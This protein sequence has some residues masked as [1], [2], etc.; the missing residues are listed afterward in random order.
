M[1]NRLIETIKR[2]LPEVQEQS[3]ALREILLSNLVMISE[4]PSPTFNEADRVHFLQ[5]RFSE[6]GL[7]NCSTD[8]VGNALGVLPGRDE[9][10]NI[11]VV[12]HADTVFPESVDHTVSVHEQFVTGAG[13][14]DDGLGL[15][16][17]CTLPTLLER[18]D[19]QLESSLV[20]MGASRSL[21]RGNLEGLRFFLDNNRLPIQAGVCVEGVQL[22]RLSLASIGML[23]G[24]IVCRV[25]DEYDWTR[26]GMTSAIT[27]LNEIITRIMELP[28]PTR[29]RTSIVLGSIRGGTSHGTIARK[30][31]LGF[32]I[33]SE[34]GEVTRQIA[35]D[36]EDRAAEVASQSGSEVTFDIFASRKPGGV[37]F[38]HP[39][40]R[41]TREI[42]KELSI[43]SR[44]APSTSELSAFID[45]GI[46]AITIGMTTCE[47]LNDLD[48]ELHIAPIS[49]GLAQLL[50]IILAIDGG[51]CD[52]N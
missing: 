49:T 20:L 17:L 24:E 12:A 11:L 50:G 33:R 48:E 8:E 5:Q 35:Q 7:Q 46:P 34:S 44:V 10:R 45:S 25:S 37:S 42:M 16:V 39:L 47:K 9:N 38:S 22:G 21:G 18:L 19:I 30:A 28:I 14:A 13:V 52:D 15:A 26:F 2:R 40:A 6:C 41:C 1:S 29:P 32:E 36:M 4:I 3:D 27:T 43:Q 31:T 51:V 23:R